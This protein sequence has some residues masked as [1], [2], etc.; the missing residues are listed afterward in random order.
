MLTEAGVALGTVAYMSPEQ[1][2]GEALDARTDLFSFGVVLYEMATGVRLFQGATSAVIFS[3]ILHH[4]ADFDLAPGLDLP[5]GLEVL[6]RAM[7]RKDRAERMQSAAA[8]RTAIEELNQETS[9]GITPLRSRAFGRTA[10]I[11]SLAMLLIAIAAAAYFRAGKQR[12]SIDSLTVLPF[13]SAAGSESQDDIADGLTTALSS[14]LGRMSGLHLVAGAATAKYRGSKKTVLEAGRELN[15]QAV[16]SGSVV[17][18]GDR[19]RIA[20]SLVSVGDN[21]QLWTE[22]YDRD[23][24][25]LADVEREILSALSIQ[26]AHAEPRKPGVEE[27]RRVDPEAYNLYL[28]GLSHALRT[29]EQDVDQAIDL[30]EKS[31][32]LDPSF[33]RAQAYLAFAY[34]TKANRIARA[35]PSGKKKASRRF[36]KLCP[37]IRTRLKRILRKAFC[38]GVHRTVFP[39]AKRSRN[40]GKRSSASQVSMRLGTSTPSSYFMWAILPAG[41]TKLRRRSRSIPP[42]RRPGFASVRCTFTS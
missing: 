7:L 1:A 22:T 26:I 31:T 34:S 3:A 9:G 6:M 35:M 32:A 40:S 12:A 17:R 5:R 21:R 11:G 23:S 20:M 38:F 10:L 2:R 18:S 13:E 8:V 29:N 42:T 37:S 39:T 19:I 25:E 15:T 30:F 27:T 4:D 24:S 33:V 14:D 16:L 41:C 28:R 36:R